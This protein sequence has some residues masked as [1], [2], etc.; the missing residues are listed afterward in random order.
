MGSTAT[1][2]YEQIENFINFPNTIFQIN[3]VSTTYTAN[4]LI[5]PDPNAGNKLYA[6]GCNWENDPN[7]PNYRSCLG[8]GKYGGGVTVVYNVTILSTAPTG[9]QTL[10]NLIYDFSGSS[11]HYNADFSVGARIA[12]IIDPT[13]LTVAKSFTPSAT[14]AGGTSTMSV[15]ITNPNAAQISKINFTDTF[16]TTPGAMVTSGTTYTTSGC[17]TPTVRAPIGGGGFT[18]GAASFSATSITIAANSSC[19]IS[20]PITAPV[21]GPPT[22][23]NTTSNSVRWHSGYY[24]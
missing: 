14:S 21:A 18:S 17:G 8:V 11:Y 7:S 12:D 20:L 16:P 19:T 2:G 4:D 24:P 22:Y 10:T 5:T 6:D 1:N 15:T 13:D 9:P 3:S 23:N